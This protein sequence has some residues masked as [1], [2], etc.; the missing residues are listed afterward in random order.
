MSVPAYCAEFQTWRD[1]PADQKASIA[2]DQF[3]HRS[4]SELFPNMAVADLPSVIAPCGKPF[5][6]CNSADLALMADWY[7]AW[8]AA[9]KGVAAEAKARRALSSAGVKF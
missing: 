8:L 7:W 2:R 6:D 4:T 3:L 1:A 5:D 9:G